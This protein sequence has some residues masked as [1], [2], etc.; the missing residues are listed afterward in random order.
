[1]F[2]TRSKSELVRSTFSLVSN[3]SLNDF[4]IRF[5]NY[6]YLFRTNTS[7][8][9]HN[10]NMFSYWYLNDVP[11]IKISES[12]SNKNKSTNDFLSF[13]YKKGRTTLSK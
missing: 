5:A 13:V 8:S 3:L 6:N 11:N 4:A 7:I 1:M 10:S 2:N 9:K 12:Q